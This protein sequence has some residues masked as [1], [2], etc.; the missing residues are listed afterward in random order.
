M[1][2]SS[3]S[4]SSP[5]V[6]CAGLPADSEQLLY[7][8]FVMLFVWLALQNVKALCS[9]LPSWKTLLLLTILSVIAFCGYHVYNATIW[10]T[11]FQTSIASFFPPSHH[12]TH[13][14]PISGSWLPS[15]WTRSTEL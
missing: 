8:V 12:N 1:E 15:S 7:W 2:T 10:L 5:Y 9:V 3:G 4:S 14:P 11:A 13:N 6:V